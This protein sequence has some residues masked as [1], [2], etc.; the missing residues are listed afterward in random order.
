MR[1]IWNDNF[2]LLEIIL[3]EH[4]SSGDDP[5]NVE[6]F[7]KIDDDKLEEMLDSMSDLHETIDVACDRFDFDVDDVV[8]YIKE[9]IEEE[10]NNR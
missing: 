9:C 8:D 1:N 6:C 3:D 7:N 2:D 4:Y 10:M 5:S